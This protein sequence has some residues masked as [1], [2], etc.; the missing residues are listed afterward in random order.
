TYASIKPVMIVL[1]WTAIPTLEASFDEMNPPA[2]VG[3]RPDLVNASSLNVASQFLIDRDGM[4]F[5]QLPDTAFARHTIGLNYCAIGIEN[6][7]SDKDL[8]TEAQ[9]KANAEL[10]RYLA[11]KYPIKYLIGHYEYKQ[12]IHH[13]LWKEWDPNYL[14]QK[15]DPGIVFMQKIREELKDL[16]LLGA[17]A[18]K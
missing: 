8:L 9:L 10:V 6:V 13:P 5:R 4:I 16:R 1:H 15:T 17:P 7:G 18:V 3:K 2:L 12:F 11:K 14:T